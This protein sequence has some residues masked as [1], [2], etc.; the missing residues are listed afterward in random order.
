MENETGYKSG[1]FPSSGYTLKAAEV[2][3]KLKRDTM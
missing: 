3:V 1:I 2:D